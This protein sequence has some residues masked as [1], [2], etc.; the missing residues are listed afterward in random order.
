M[1][2]LFSWGLLVLIGL[3]NSYI[4]VLLRVEGRLLHLRPPQG[5]LLGQDLLLL[6]LPEGLREAEFSVHF[7]LAMI[8]LGE[9]ML[10]MASKYRYLTTSLGYKYL[11]GGWWGPKFHLERLM[12]PPPGRRLCRVRLSIVLLILFLKEPHSELLG[13]RVRL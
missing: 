6:A 12:G 5:P 1:Y 2:C 10:G 9:I 7:P 3:S 11:L 4:G 8:Y 13:L